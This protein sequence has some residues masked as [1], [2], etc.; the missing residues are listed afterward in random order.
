MGLNWILVRYWLDSNVFIEGSK[1]PYGFD[2]APQFWNI[3][4]KMVDRGLLA[5]PIQVY[6]ELQGAPGDLA[7]W[8]QKNRS[9][10]M[11]VNPDMAVQDEF[12]NVAEYTVQHYPDNAPRKRFLDRADPWIIAH[13]IVTEGTVVTLESRN[14]DGSNKVKIPNVCKHFG[15]HCIDTYQMLREQGI[16]WR[17]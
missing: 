15:V 10:D 12:R 6:G 14:P 13:A 1:G 8:A 9:T 2:L 11:F 17:D 7:A 5:C 16:A 4:E 3:L